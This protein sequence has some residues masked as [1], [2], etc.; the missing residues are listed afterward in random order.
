MKRSL[1]LI[2]NM[3][4]FMEECLVQQPSKDDVFTLNPYYVR[5]PET[6]SSLKKEISRLYPNLAFLPFEE[7]KVYSWNIIY[8]SSYFPEEHLNEIAAFDHTEIILVEDGLFDYIEYEKG[9][10]AFYRGKQLYVFRPEIASDSAKAT[11]LHKLTIDKS[12]VHSFEEL[13]SDSLR[14]LRLYNS[15]TPVLFTT[16]LEEDFSSEETLTDRIMT[17]L[18]D[19][20]EI[21]HII[22]KKHPRDHFH[23]NSPYIKITECPQNIP[24]QFLDEIFD[25]MKI[26]LFPSTVSFMCGELSDITFLNVMPDNP[27]Y[28]N[29]FKQ[30]IDS[31]ILSGLITVK[32]EILP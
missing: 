14:A 20:Y 4:I 5:D 8:M 9:S 3:M 18:N 10:Y 15:K 22:L 26:F 12:I 32:I 2:Q 6:F 23:Y 28:T 21:N 11:D 19:R 7:C 16:P 13:Y 27:E 1:Y 17:F 24:G 25:G 29:A 30:V 31:N